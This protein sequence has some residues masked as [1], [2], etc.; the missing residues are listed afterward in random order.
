MTEEE[1]DA[2]FLAFAKANETILANSLDVSFVEVVHKYRQV[3]ADFHARAGDDAFF[4]LE[5]RRRIAERILQATNSHDQPFEVCHN[6]WNDLLRLGFSNIEVTCWMT[7]EYAECCLFN[8]QFDAGIAVLTPLIADLQ[9][10]LSDPAVK[11]AGFYR[12][13]LEY[14]GRLLAELQAAQLEGKHD[15]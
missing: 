15:D 4:K 14:L 5:T 8:E 12:Q 10:R 3:E 13:E 7:R 6:A 11:G 1:R 2:L 9:E